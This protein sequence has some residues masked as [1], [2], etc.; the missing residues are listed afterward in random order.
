[1]NSILQNEELASFSMIPEGDGKS[2]FDKSDPEQLTR[3][4][5]LEMAQQRAAWTEAEGRHRKIRAMSLAFLVLI[6]IGGLLAFFLL[7]TRFAQEHPAPTSRSEPTAT[8]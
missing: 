1:M 4:I 2:E 3:M 8:P 7:F 6:V 5:E